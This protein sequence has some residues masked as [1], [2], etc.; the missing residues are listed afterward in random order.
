MFACKKSYSIFK[1]SGKCLHDEKVKKMCYK[2]QPQQKRGRNQ[3]NGLIIEKLW[4]TFLLG[5]G[6]KC[7]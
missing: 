4:L 5:G 6:T 3:F 7:Y 1:P 2:R